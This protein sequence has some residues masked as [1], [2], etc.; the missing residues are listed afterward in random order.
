M[1]LPQ[2]A[3]RQFVRWLRQFMVPYVKEPG[4]LPE[5]NLRSH[6]PVAV[7]GFHRLPDAMQPTRPQALFKPSILPRLL[8]LPQWLKNGF[9]FFPAFFAGVLF[10]ADVIGRLLA[11]FLSFSLVASAIYLVNDLR[12]VEQD[13]LHPVKRLRPI[14][15]G[16]VDPALV[17]WASALLALAGLGWAWLTD[18]H[19]AMVLAAYAALNLLYSFR[20]K[21][22]PI[23]DVAIIAIGFLLRVHSG[24]ILAHVPNSKWILLVTFLL[25]LFLA[26]AK[27]RNDLV[28]ANGGTDLRA[29]L[30]GYN[31]PF[32]DASMITLAALVVQSYILY[33][34]SEDVIERLGTDRVYITSGF[35]VLGMMRYFQLTLVEHRT[36]DPTKLVF[37]DRPIQLIILAWAISFGIILYAG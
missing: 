37:K 33:T 7:A 3:G 13:R 20:L 22:I 29:S 6:G 36:G 5:L 27:R 15:A 34:V 4:L 26:L 35:V 9:V 8:R 2:R 14:A 10:Q 32:V 19:F 31:L 28:Q 1:P 23:V 21:H 25:A 11:G 18:I 12:D 17:P 24:G 16:E 30:R